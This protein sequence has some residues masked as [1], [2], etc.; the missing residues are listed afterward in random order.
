M[1]LSC[2]KLVHESQGAMVDVPL[3]NALEAKSVV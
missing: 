3:L 2:H 1:D